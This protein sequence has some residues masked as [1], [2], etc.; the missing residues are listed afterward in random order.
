MKEQGGVSEVGIEVAG[1]EGS[2][3]AGHLIRQGQ[4]V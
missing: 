4:G 3:V 1:G 2:N